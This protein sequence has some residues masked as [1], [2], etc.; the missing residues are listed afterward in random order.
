M[1][2]RMEKRITIALAIGPVIF[3]SLLLVIWRQQEP[4]READA[5]AT[6]QRAVITQQLQQLS[7]RHAR[8]EELAAHAQAAVAIAELTTTT[9]IL[10]DDVREMQREQR[11]RDARAAESRPPGGGG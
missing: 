6:R 9:R 4:L 8:H 3:G 7:E 1:G 5:E 2:S 11:E 10:F